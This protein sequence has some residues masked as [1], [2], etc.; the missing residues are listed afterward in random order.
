[1]AKILL[2]E[3]VPNTYRVWEQKLKSGNHSVVLVDLPT[4]AM[5][6][7]E[8]LRPDLVLMDVYFDNYEGSNIPFHQRLDGDEAGV[9]IYLR[10][11]I[12]VVFFTVHPEV[13]KRAAPVK[14][15]ADLFGYLPKTGDVDDK[16]VLDLIRK[17][18][19]KHSD[20]ESKRGVFALDSALQFTCMNA[21]AKALL[22]DNAQ[23]A[24]PSAVWESGTMLTLRKILAEPDLKEGKAM[25]TTLKYIANDL[26]LLELPVALYPIIS[27][28]SVTGIRCEW[29]SNE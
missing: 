21:M 23:K 14:M 17:A 27:R 8:R 19:L 1:M 5:A 7:A 11:N 16:H 13:L 29:V 15:L 24:N 9:Q 20:L 3:D 10:Y 26:S 25:V 6:E 22:G 18:L 4:K 28:K 12:P 2:A